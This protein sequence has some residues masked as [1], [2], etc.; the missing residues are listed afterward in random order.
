MSH[1]MQTGHVYYV[2]LGTDVVKIGYSSAGVGSRRAAYKAA[3][4]WLVV[5]YTV[6]GEVLNNVIR[7]VEAEL[8][9]A[10][11]SAGFRII[12]GRE[13]YEPSL[14]LTDV[15]RMAADILPRWHAIGA[16]NFHEAAIRRE[17]ARKAAS[18]RWGK[19]A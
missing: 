14:T 7:D 16:M 13:Y 12:G 8:H 4:P 3:V 17:Q 6:I 1:E 15:Q 19:A 5:D 9:A 10:I 11:Q 2:R 18:A